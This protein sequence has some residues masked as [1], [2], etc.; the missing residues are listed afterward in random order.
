MKEQPKQ[1][2]AEFHKKAGIAKTEA[3][4]TEQSQPPKDVLIAKAF[5]PVKETPYIA[6]PGSV[7]DFKASAIIFSQGK[8]VVS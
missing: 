6:I 7:E 1:E 2:V 3:I 4:K 5:L 8:K